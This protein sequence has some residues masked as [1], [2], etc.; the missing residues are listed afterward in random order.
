MLH[1]KENEWHLPFRA[2][3]LQRKEET[4]RSLQNWQEKEENLTILEDLT[5]LPGI[6]MV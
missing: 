3:K 1:A 2:S 6:V 5:T 4:M